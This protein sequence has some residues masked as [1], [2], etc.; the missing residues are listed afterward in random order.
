MIVRTTADNAD[1]ADNEAPLET[2]CVKAW[3]FQPKIFS[4]LAY[5]KHKTYIS[6]YRKEEHRK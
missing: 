4:V 6:S 2:L 5:S 3:K 1:T